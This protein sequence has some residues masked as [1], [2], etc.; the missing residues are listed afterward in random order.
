MALAV[1]VVVRYRK[2]VTYGVHALLA[3]LDTAG[4]EYELS[5]GT[6][7]EETAAHIE[8]SRADRVLVLWSFYSPDAD[9]M[10]SE[11]ATVRSST[12]RPD[13]LHIAG[14]VHA[15]AE[16]QQVLDAGWDV[17][18]IGEGES[19]IVAL[20]RATPSPRSSPSRPCANSTG[21]PSA[22]TPTGTGASRPSTRRGWR[23]RPTTPGVSGAAVRAKGRRRPPGGRG[24]ASRRRPAGGTPG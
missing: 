16:P 9:A 13:V 5:L 7:A 2:A 10:A 24:R 6:T 15:T 17:A 12:G 1:N 21:W 3:A 11:L 14:G 4:L 19:T 18:A 8:A 23:R 20:V 22:A